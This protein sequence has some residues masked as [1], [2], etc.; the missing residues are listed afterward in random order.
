[1]CNISEEAAVAGHVKG[2]GHPSEQRPSPREV[3]G[4][5][6]LRLARQAAGHG[7]GS[8]F[9]PSH[10]GRFQRRDWERAPLWKSLETLMA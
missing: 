1:M 10:T 8:G 5:D 7:Q 4:A 2:R 3:G 6:V 9:Y